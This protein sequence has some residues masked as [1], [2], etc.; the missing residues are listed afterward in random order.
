MIDRRVCTS[1]AAANTSSASRI[2]T[3]SKV[4]T[5]WASGPRVARDPRGHVVLVAGEANFIDEA[6]GGDAVWQMHAARPVADDE[7]LPPRHA[8]AQCCPCIEKIVVSLPIA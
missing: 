2:P 1:P 8:L 4:A 7:Q 3:A 5:R 6:H